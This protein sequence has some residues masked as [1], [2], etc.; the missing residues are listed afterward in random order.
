MKLIG[1]R[2]AAGLALENTIG[3]LEA[4]IRAG[5]DAVEIDIRATKDGHLVLSHDDSLERVFGKKVRV[6]RITKAQTKKIKTKGGQVLVPLDEA[7]EKTRGTPIVI[8]GKSGRWARPLQKLL[9]DTHDK[10][11]TTVISFNHEE[12][13]TFSQLCPDIPCYVLEHKNPFDAINAARLYDFEGIDVNFWTLNPLAYWLAK[14]H[15]LKVIVYTVNKPWLARMIDR[16]YP[17]AVITTNVPNK[18]QFLRNKQ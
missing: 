3:S 6:S 18:L 16:I 12:L 13:Y 17:E 11:R 14:R 7:L 9:D 4:A 1:H 10:G 5:V 2:G 15:G 8:E